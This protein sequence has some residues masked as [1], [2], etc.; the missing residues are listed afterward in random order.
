[1]DST[2]ARRQWANRSGEYSP[3]Y[4][5]YY[6][7]NEA[8]EWIREDLDGAV[9]HDA[10]V[11]E[12]GC[13]SGRHLAHLHDHG[14]T[15]LAGVEVN[16]EAV[17]VM[18]DVYPDTA[19]AADVTVAPIE[20]VVT[21]FADDEFD[22]VFAVE[23]LQH[24][25]PE[26]EWVFDEIARVAGERLLTVEIEGDDEREPGEY[27]VNYVDE[28]LPLFYRN[29][30]HVF[31]TRGWEQVAVHEEGNDTLRAFRPQRD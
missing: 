14:Y 12:L 19:A 5:A 4:Y 24:L 20:E 6:G 16:A 11:L 15:D 30:E 17:D 9:G 10:S 7:P 21:D 18:A 1:M 13:S 22:A 26:A 29:W 3:R 2:D 25:D 23:V 28:G 31:T 8:S 27:D